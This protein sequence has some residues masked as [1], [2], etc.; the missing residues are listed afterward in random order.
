[1]KLSLT[2]QAAKPPL[3]HGLSPRTRAALLAALALGLA[4]FALAFWFAVARPV[5]VLPRMDPLPAF[6]LEDQYGLPINSSDLLGRT[7]FVNFTY[8]GCGEACAAQREALVALREALRA[9]GRLGSEV[10]FL[11]V[12]FDPARDS[13]EAL[14]V[15]AAQLGAERGSWRFVTGEPAELKALI[16]GELGFYYGKP[17]AAGAI[18]HDQRVLLVDRNGLM[19][20]KYKAESLS[21]ATLLRD[22][23][24]VEQEL[25]S[26]GVMRGVYEASHIFLCY[27][28]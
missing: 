9:D 4:I 13:R 2:H 15:Y 26:A 18:E 22:I 1:M 16:G 12:S 7:V 10:I 3:S 27:P 20:A 6:A 19:R 24:L 14:Q 28:D 17:D 23:G 25:G 11:T 21:V 5:K 8:T